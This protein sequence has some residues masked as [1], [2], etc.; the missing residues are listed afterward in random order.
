MRARPILLFGMPRSGTSWLGKVFDSHP[1]T[2][3]RHEPDSGGV[4]DARMPLMAPVED[5]ER[6]REAAARYVDSLI[7]N[8]ALR[9][10][11]KL[12]SFPKA[13]QTRLAARA[14]QALLIGAKAVSRWVPVG[15]IPEFVRPGYDGKLFLA[16]KSIESLGR[17]GVFAR[18]LPHAR[19]VHIIRHPCGYVASVL[20]G[21]AGGHL[22]GAVPGSEDYGIFGILLATAAA[23]RRGLTLAALQALHPVERLAWRW[24]LSNEKALEDLDG[25]PNGRTVRYEDLC[26][27]PLDGYRALF[28]FAGLSWD[29]QSSAFILDSTSSE[30]SA[31]FSVFKDPE[32][33]AAGWKSKLSPQD[34]ARVLG[35][36]AG[37]RAGAL[38]ET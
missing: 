7:A 13:Y 38:Y 30:K 18:A 36:V 26:R 32:R 35:V 14:R 25:L 31:Y 20:G 23:R 37:S 21:E 22:P 11:G 33:A 2:L 8:R 6:Y 4:L 19:A 1:L 24:L 15:G 28:E 29:A 12:P 17:L 9:V 3:Y 34:Q 5:V 27:N 16:W 10:T